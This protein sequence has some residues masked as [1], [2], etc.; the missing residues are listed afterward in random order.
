MKMQGWW[1]HRTSLR[2]DYRFKEEAD[3]ADIYAL[4][5]CAVEENV[6][7]SVEASEY[8]HTP[9]FMRR[10][11]PSRAGLDVHTVSMRN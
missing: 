3:V 11:S 8:R 7:Y 9:E 10:G 5:D 1:D 6:L 4:L 2:E